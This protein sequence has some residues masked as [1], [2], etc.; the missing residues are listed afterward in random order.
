[1][2]GWEKGKLQAQPLEI[3]LLIPGV[4]SRVATNFSLLM[5]EGDK[6]WLFLLNVRLLMHWLAARFTQQMEVTLLGF[7][8]KDQ[9]LI[10]VWHWGPSCGF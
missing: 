4:C 6:M 9:F 3:L 10:E 1:V 2:T 7:V 8:L 5:L